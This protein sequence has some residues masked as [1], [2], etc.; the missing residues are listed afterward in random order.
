MSGELGNPARGQADGSVE[1]PSDASG[2]LAFQ[3]RRLVAADLDAV[4]AIERV[5]YDFPW[6]RGNFSD[7]LQAGYD[8]WVFEHHDSLLGYAVIMWLPDEVHLL[9]VSVTRAMQG[10]GYGR[11]MMHWLLNDS[12]NRGAPAMMLEV[13]PSNA[14]ARRLYESL[15]FRQ[16]GVRRRYYPALDGR[17]DALVM[18]KSLRHG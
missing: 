7:S 15:G 6:T 18:L 11:A 1:R 10:K 5:I 9:N 17:E 3:V 12:K 2:R 8:L 14:T 13:R 4:A 16:I